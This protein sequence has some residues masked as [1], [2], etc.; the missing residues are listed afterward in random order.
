[1]FFK[2]ERGTITESEQQEKQKM[3]IINAYCPVNV[4]F[5]EAHF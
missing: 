3:R 5:H 4:T 2:R 1:M